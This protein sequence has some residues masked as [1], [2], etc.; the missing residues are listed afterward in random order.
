M[1]TRF[2]RCSRGGYC[3]MLER[4]KKYLHIDMVTFHDDWG[5]QRAPFFSLNTCMEMIVLYLK[6]ICARAHE[7]GMIFELHSCGMD[8][9]LVPAML[10]SGVDMWAG[11]NLNSWE[12]SP[13]STATDSFTTWSG[14]NSTPSALPRRRIFPASASKNGSITTKA[15]PAF[16]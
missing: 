12:K 2:S 3:E 6:R 9:P 14:K 1:C 5:T 7:L 4:M 8:E 15:A 11:Q 13:L 16:G 10:E